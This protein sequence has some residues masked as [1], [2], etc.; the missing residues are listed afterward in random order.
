MDVLYASSVVEYLR[1]HFECDPKWLFSLS[2]KQE[3]FIVAMLCCSFAFFKICVPLPGSLCDAEW[4]TLIKAEPKSWIKSK[5]FEQVHN[6][7]FHE[8]G[9]DDA[10]HMLPASSVFGIAAIQAILVQ[11]CI[12]TF[13]YVYTFIPESKNMP[14]V[15]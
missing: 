12:F 5:S 13:I 1:I 4:C 8:W 3:V 11:A 9:K 15:G 2:L 6:E 14:K 10:K 7:I